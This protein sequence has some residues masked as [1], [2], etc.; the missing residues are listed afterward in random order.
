MEPHSLATRALALLQKTHKLR[1]VTL[2]HSGV[3]LDTT[4]G[5]HV[6]EFVVVS[7]D[8]PNGP[9]FRTIMAADGSP[10]DR[11]PAPSL[12]AIAPPTGIRARASITI[13]P[14]ANVLTLNPGDTLDESLTVTVPKN[15][16]APMADVY[17]LADTTGSMGSVLAAVQAGA[18][19]I[20]STLGGLGLDLAF[21]V[22]HY[23][24]FPPSSPSPF[25]HQLNPASFAAPV[26]A[27]IGTW[28]AAGGGDRPEGQLLALELLAQP[29]G[30]SVG[31]RSGARRIVVWFGDAP[32]HDPICTALSGLGAAITE[33]S[34][35]AK[36]VAERITVLA[37]STASPGLDDDPK[38]ISFDYTASCGP[39]GGAAGQASRL[40]AAT[41]GV[42][43]SGIDAASIV[44]TIIS[45]V[46][47]A[48]SS[49][50]NLKLVPSAPIAPF[51]AAIAPAAGYGPLA[52]DR[53]H[54]L[55]F[56]VT[57]RGI[58]CQRADQIFNGTLDV[59]AD[60]VVVAAKQVRI[61]VPACKP[62]QMRYSVKFICGVQTDKPH[63]GCA[64]VQPGHH[65]TQI[66]IHNH[67]NDTVEIRKRFIPLV[68][69]GAPL[70]R[71]PHVAEARADDSIKLAPHT[72]T[73]DDCCRITELLLGA[74]LDGGLT[75]G[76]LEITA[77]HDVSVT[78][79]YTTG[80][81]LKVNAIK[82]RAV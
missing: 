23:R 53:E 51:V 60:G 37:I 68:L 45:L 79:V 29:P 63:C 46:T 62:K 58:P 19:Q 76:V 4:T 80:S 57:F 74:P 81:S 11:L 61:T 22:G 24:D 71:E 56:D 3:V 8:D 54:V 64:P 43:V 44:N 40:A 65:A 67:S 66:S 1:D 72:A 73:M 82:G 27:A 28:A 25:T 2:V 6:H 41:G 16:V 33:A 12:A 5:E 35:T 59:V 55:K 21:G 10:R 17:F 47:A 42:L 34:A 36:L 39:P 49:I 50:N 78:A 48:V 9:S 15:A 7:A 52:G 38:P 18:S 32:G 20:L 75:L 26:A 31:W 69:A 70:G 13:Q 30:G 77:S 14:D